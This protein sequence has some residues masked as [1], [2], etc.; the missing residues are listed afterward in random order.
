MPLLMATSAFGLGRRHQN[1]PEW[2]YRHILCTFVPQKEHNGI[3][4]EAVCRPDIPPL[5]QPTLKPT[6]VIKE[7][8]GIQSTM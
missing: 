3:T 7:T 4:G 2:C 5:T 6:D 8:K 1:S